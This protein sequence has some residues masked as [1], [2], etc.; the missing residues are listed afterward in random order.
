MQAL[1]REVPVPGGAKAR[2][3]LVD[4][5]SS[6]LLCPSCA[7]LLPETYRVCPH[8][9]TPLGART[10]PEDPLVGAL[11][12]HTY[13]VVRRMARGGMGRLY[14][15]EHVRL[16]RRV[17]LKVMHEHFAANPDLVARFE[18]EARAA[19]RIRHPNVLEVVDVVR[20]PCGR[21]AIVAEYLEGNDLQVELDR[22]DRPTTRDAIVWTRDLARGLGAAHDAG[23]VHR[24]VKP[25]N[26]FLAR[27]PGGIVV[28]VL[29][30]G[31][32]KV[33]GDDKLTRTGA[34]VGTP[35]Y[36]APEQARGALLADARSD[37]YA[38]GALLYRLA[39]GFTPYEPGDPSTTLGRVLSE[40]PRPPRDLA[41]DLPI[42]VEAV[43]QRAMARDPSLRFES[44]EALASAL[45][46][47]ASSF[48]RSPRT[49][50]ESGRAAEALVREA[51]LARPLAA[52]AALGAALVAALATAATIGTWIPHPGTDEGRLLVAFAALVGGLGVGLTLARD[53]SACWRS[54][55]ACLAQARQIARSLFAG[56][57]VASAI[58]LATAGSAA[59]RGEAA[60]GLLATRF[61]LAAMASL[62]VHAFVRRAAS[63]GA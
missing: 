4:E 51:R 28:K 52:S 13:R 15:A 37:V 9:G 41:P 14:E 7:R 19:S 16:G 11:V 59:L 43:V 33:A 57:L 53:L 38:V 5:P 55:P 3:A 22:H 44:M 54:A 25:S 31:V 32:A 60:P 34:V 61:V 6:E 27:T 1:A 21:P 8:D 50:P 18:R 36:M 48:E 30:F 24:D 45:D 35:A 42:A 10:A 46:A 26:V 63:R 2:P 40:D 17:T 56:L 20:T 29:D 39:T 23:V 49:L 58:E 47:I 62:L 12:A